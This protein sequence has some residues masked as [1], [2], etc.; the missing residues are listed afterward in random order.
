MD[1]VLLEQLASNLYEEKQWKR[2][3]EYG[4]W[5][6]QAAQIKTIDM[7]SWTDAETGAEGR[8][9]HNHADV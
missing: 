9:R 1:L 2:R 4:A 6:K 3:N 5:L 8:W 7:M